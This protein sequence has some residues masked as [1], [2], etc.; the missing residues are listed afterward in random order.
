MSHEMV[1]FNKSGE[2]VAYVRFTMN[3]YYALIVYD[4][5]D[6]HKHNGGPSGK[7]HS[8]TYPLSKVEEAFQSF[9]QL[10]NEFFNTEN[11]DSIPWQHVDIQ[12]FLN[13]CLFTAEKE[14]S[15]SICYF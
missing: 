13:H 4:L 1:G 2:E 11:F 12:K 14:K 15:V 5:F 3:D 9:N 8:E 10:T 6:A 7:G